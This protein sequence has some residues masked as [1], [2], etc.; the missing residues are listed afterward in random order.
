MSKKKS[1]NRYPNADVIDWV[2][3]G[4]NGKPVNKDGK[5]TSNVKQHVRD[6]SAGKV[7]NVEF[8][9]VADA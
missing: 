6:R 3:V 4:A 5:T 2:L 8:P 9:E 7:L 1:E